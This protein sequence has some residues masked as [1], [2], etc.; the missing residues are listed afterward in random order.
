[1]STRWPYL[2]PLA[3]LGIVAGFFAWSLTSDRNPASIGSALVGR[4]APT[5]N[6]APLREGE[7]AV[8]DASLRGRP[9]VVNFFASWCAPCQL[10][11]PI[12]MRLAEREGATVVGIAYKNKPADALAFLKRLGDPY[13]HAG[14]D[15]DGKIAIDWGLSGVPET[16]VIDARGIVR[17]H[18]RGPI[19][20]RD[21]KDSI[22]P[23]LKA[24]S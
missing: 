1:M 19:S 20:E 7:T 16:Y 5:L 9:V 17:L 15:P 10:E 12:L 18:F 22:L 4:P 24:G 11:H 3:T 23:A 21:L 6:A 13:K 2:L 14:L 8:T